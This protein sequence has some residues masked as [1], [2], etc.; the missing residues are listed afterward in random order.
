M[1]AAI[2]SS[3]KGAPGRISKSWTQRS[4][5]PPS[6]TGMYSCTMCM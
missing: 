4:R 5:V 1:R 2:C 3:V 6:P